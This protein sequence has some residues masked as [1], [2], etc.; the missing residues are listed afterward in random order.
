MVIH[1]N[2][3]MVKINP[4]YMIIKYLILD[5]SYTG[6][7]DGTFAEIICTFNKLDIEPGKAKVTYFFKVVE[8][9]TY[10]YSEDIITKDVTQSL[11]YRVLKEIQLLIMVKSYLNFWIFSKLGFFKYYCTNS[12]K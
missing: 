7:I 11:F 1:L 12:T 6:G 3:L 9:S 5:I 4:N 10:V 8:N 2:T